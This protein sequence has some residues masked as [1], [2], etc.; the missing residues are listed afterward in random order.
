[1]AFRGTNEKIYEDNNGNF[2]GLIEMIAE[3]D[4]VTQEYIRHINHNDIHYHYLGHKIQNELISRL[5]SNI[6]SA[7]IEKS[8]KQNIFQ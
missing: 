8:K 5:A 7:I 1:M 3:F 4:L 2:L 6:K